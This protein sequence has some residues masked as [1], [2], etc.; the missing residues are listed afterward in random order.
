VASAFVQFGQ[1]SVT[2]LGVAAASLT[3]ADFGF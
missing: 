1:G 3:A 2:L